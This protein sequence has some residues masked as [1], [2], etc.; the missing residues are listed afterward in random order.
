M[1]A[2][3]VDGRRAAIL[4][5]I[6]LG[7]AAYYVSRIGVGTLFMSRYAAFEIRSAALPD[8]ALRSIL[9]ASASYPLLIA[10]VAF[11]RLRATSPPGPRRDAYGVGFLATLP[12]LLLITNPISSARYDFGT[13]GFALAV[14]LGAMIT[15]RRARVAMGGTLFALMFVFPI[16]DAFRTDI[17]NVE[18]LG[19]FAEYSDNPDYDGFWQIANTLA[20]LHDVGLNVANQFFGV[21]FFW[22]PRAI[23]P[24]KP[25]D[26][27]ILLANYRGYSFNNLSAPL[28]AEL[29]INGST[30]LLVLGFVVIGAAL[31]RLD[32]RIAAS[33]LGRGQWWSIVGAVFPF[34]M[35]ILLRGSLLQATGAL[36]VALACLFAVR[37]PRRRQP[38]NGVAVRG[39]A[40]RSAHAGR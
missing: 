20:Y 7:T 37:S 38:A 10:A 29:M 14:A 16:A 40:P 34:Y 2:D 23:W 39:H 12:V 4:A 36:V 24:E 5:L 25:V 18:R 13:V 15:I 22:V 32:V 35:V 30:A 3:S 28:W 17:V 11:A 9:D 8:L 21:M 26:T 6:G 27:G 1:R 19:F 33:L 31:R